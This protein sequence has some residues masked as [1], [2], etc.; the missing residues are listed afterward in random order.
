MESNNNEKKRK[1]DSKYRKKLV[2]KINK[3]K[4]KIILMEIYDIIKNNNNIKFSKNKNGV[5][6]D[7]NK[8]SDDN[9]KNVTKI[10]DDNIDLTTSEIKFSYI[11]YSNTNEDEGLS[12]KEKNILKKC[13]N[14]NL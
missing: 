5:F 12:N 8:L 4:D 6:F 1:Y 3:I 11:P 13:K 10:V 14:I 7:M 9:I 2:E